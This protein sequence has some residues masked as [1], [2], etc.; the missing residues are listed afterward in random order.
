MRQ[1]NQSLDSQRSFQRTTARVLTALT[2]SVAATLTL[3]APAIY[4][5]APLF[6]LGDSVN[7]LD[8][9]LRGRHVDLRPSAFYGTFAAITSLGISLWFTL[10]AQCILLFILWGLACRHL[11]PERPG[12][13]FFSGTFA[14][15]LLSPA[16]LYFSRVH[17][18]VFALFIFFILLHLI[19]AKSMSG[20]LIAAGALFLISAFHVSF[21]PITASAFLGALIQKVKRGRKALFAALLGLLLVA[22]A[23]YYNTTK[24]GEP[25][26]YRV[27][28]LPLGS[29]IKGG[30]VVDYLRENCAEKKYMLCDHLDK[31]NDHPGYFFWVVDETKITDKAGKERVAEYKRLLKDIVLNHPFS[32]LQL[33]ILRTGEQLVTFVDSWSLLNVYLP[34]G[35][36]RDRF[37]SDYR[38]VKSS[39]QMTH[40]EVLRNR[41][42]SIASIQSTLYPFIVLAFLLILITKSR[43]VSRDLRTALY[44]LPLYLLI[45]AAICGALSTPLARYQARVIGLLP[46]FT[47]AVLIAGRDFKTS[48]RAE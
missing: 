40:N 37:P 3:L 27:A 6:M 38:Q 14:L 21:L 19:T 34:E 5:G 45:N 7:Y 32:V 35:I 24:H 8:E 10:L 23:A 39:Y 42:E 11:F 41:F 9:G 26:P 36:L 22:S 17:P 47:L 15:A 20:H 4:N 48:E 1:S 44:W 16:P 25:F 43:R 46:M 2:L 13:I 30:L 18:D 28:A 29:L 33:W 12:R 31:I